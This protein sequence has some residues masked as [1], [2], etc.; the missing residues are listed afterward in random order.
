M[1]SADKL[2]NAFIFCHN[3]DVM[4]NEIVERVIEKY[5]EQQPKW[6]IKNNGLPL[7]ILDHITKLFIPAVN[8]PYLHRPLI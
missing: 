2:E 7:T 8:N 5:S 6:G 3:S 1:T 4:N